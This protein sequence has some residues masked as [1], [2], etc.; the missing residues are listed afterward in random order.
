MSNE[1]KTVRASGFRLLNIGGRNRKK[2]IIVIIVLA[3]IALSVSLFFVLGAKNIEG[4]TNAHLRANG[5]EIGEI[6]DIIVR[7]SFKSPFANEWTV[8]VEYYEEPGVNYMYY[9]RDG[10]VKFT[11]I[12]GGELKDKSEY[13]YYEEIE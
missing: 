12:A 6:D 7:Y 8:S 5:V 2:T 9:Y 13:K 3:V 11:G 4:K 1:V 10:K